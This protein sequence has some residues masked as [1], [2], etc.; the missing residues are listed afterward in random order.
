MFPITIDYRGKKGTYYCYGN[1]Q[2][3]IKNGELFRA[4]ING[5]EIEV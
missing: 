2:N 4:V 1:G 5:K 3:A